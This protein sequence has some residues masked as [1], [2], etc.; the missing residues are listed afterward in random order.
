MRAD[1]NS[2]TVSLLPEVIRGLDRLVERGRFDSRAEALRYGARLA[3]REEQQQRLDEY[4]SE[5][6]SENATDGL[7]DR[8]DD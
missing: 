4:A 2:V 7:N 8:R 1:S 5:K 6:T 3:V